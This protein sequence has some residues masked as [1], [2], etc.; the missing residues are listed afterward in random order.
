M[1]RLQKIFSLIPK[2][3]T[4]ADIGCDHG[5]LSKMAADSKKA[6]RIY[7]SDISAPSLEKAKKLLCGY[8]NVEFS[9]GDGFKSL[10][11]IPNAAAVAGMGGLEI[12][13]IIAGFTVPVLILQPQN[14]VPD[15]RLYLSQ[16]GYHIAADEI[17]KENGKFYF[18]IKA[19]Y[20]AAKQ[21]ILEPCQLEYGVFYKIKNPL[22]KEKLAIDKEKL[23][24]FRQTAANAAKLKIIEEVEKWQQ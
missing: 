3:E 1:D 19:E 2:C 21:T 14:K 12:I 8:E 11:L 10:P 15:V 23:L 6:A 22:L 18:V 16:N 5:K 9:V 17:V 7:A 24:S 20:F 4:F 13:K